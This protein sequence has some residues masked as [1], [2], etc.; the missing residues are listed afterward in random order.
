M[1]QLARPFLVGVQFPRIAFSFK[2][3]IISK[4]LEYLDDGL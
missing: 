3:T 4:K 2:I 1:L